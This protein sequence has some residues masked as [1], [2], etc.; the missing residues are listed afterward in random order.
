M[1]KRIF[2]FSAGP[3]TLPLDVLKKV[4]AEFLD[5]HGTGMSLIEMSHR[6]KEFDEV[7]NNTMNSLRELMG[8]SDKYKILFVGGGASSQFAMIP[9][10][11][12]SK[13]KTAA[14]VDTGAW[15]GKA[16]KEAKAFGSV[17][18]AGSSKDGG[19]T[20]VPKTADIDFP[21]DAA[22]L[23]M[24]S[25]NTIFGTQFQEYPDTGSV[26]LI[27]DMSSDILSRQLDFNKFSVIY[28]GA[29]KNLG[30]AGV[31][32]VI[33]HEDMLV[34]CNDGIPTMFDYRTHANK[35]SLYNTPPVFAIYIVG[36]VAEWIK[37]QGGLAA[38]E[39][40][41][42]AKKERIY[43]M[44]DLNP[45]YYKGTVQD[46]SR[47][48]MNLTFRLPSEDLEKKFIAEASAAG[49]S[50]LK[51]HRSVGGVRASIYNAMTLEGVEK[52]V[53]F[54]ESFKKAN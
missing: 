38:I 40:M 1:A 30:P 37:E 31:T 13:G 5:Y 54:M 53:E 23:H 3:S 45:D 8:L 22:Y 39:K 11:F 26:P 28:A 49:F 47:S 42:V 12:L 51:G 10:N 4:Q 15:A 27:C 9:M 29:Q 50:G 34:K 2:N 20:F 6:S 25:N 36:L 32:I 16:Y 35:D 17:H 52:L 24:T 44:I 19:H 33:V 46:E 18:L 48:W 14:Y 41:N 21:S 43:Q 7:N